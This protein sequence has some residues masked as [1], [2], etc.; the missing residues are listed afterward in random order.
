M[1]QLALAWLLQKKEVASVFVA[2]RSPEE[3]RV[4]MDAADRDVPA[5]VLARATAASAAVRA[6]LGDNA[7]VWMGGREVTLRL[8]TSEKG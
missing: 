6:K 5:D 2:S 8:R 4:S 1:S 7:D 3:L